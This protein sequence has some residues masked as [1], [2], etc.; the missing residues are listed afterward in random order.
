MKM[1]LAYTIDVLPPVIVVLVVIA[2]IAWLIG[3]AP[4]RTTILVLVYV[5]ICGSAF[6]LAAPDARW[7]VL[8]SISTALAVITALFSGEIHKLVYRATLTFKVDDDLIDT[9][10]GQIWIRG[11]VTNRG[12][13]AV[14]GGRM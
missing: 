13:C 2:I 5:I 12:E 10:H 7:D 1:R 4:V 9:A 11:R 3:R 14:E 8:L 6:Q